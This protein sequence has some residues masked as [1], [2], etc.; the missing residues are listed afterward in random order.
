[1]AIQY[2]PNQPIQLYKQVGG[3][4]IRQWDRTAYHKR[5]G[6]CFFEGPNYCHPVVNT[7]YM[8]FQF[9]ASEI[10][11]DLLL[12]SITT[13]TGS[14]TSTTTDH[15]IDSGADFVAAGIQLNNLVVNINDNTSAYVDNVDSLTNL[16]LSEDIF[17]SFPNDYIIYNINIDGNWKFNYNTGEFFVDNA[18][19]GGVEFPSILNV[20]SWYAVTINVT[21]ITAGFISIKLGNNTIVNISSVGTHTVYGQCTIV[22]D[23]TFV[24]SS[25]FL[26]AFDIDDCTVIEMQTEYTIAI[27]DIDGVFQSA[28]GG[29]F[30]DIDALSIGNIIINRRWS[31]FELDCGKYIVAVYEGDVAP[32][33]G[34]MVRN[35]NFSSPV[36]WATDPPE[37]T[38]AGGAALFADAPDGSGLQNTL[39]C[40]IQEERSYTL[41][42]DINPGSGSVKK[43]EYFILTAQGNIGGVI[44][45]DA[46]TQTGTQSL[47]F[48]ATANSSILSFLV[49]DSGSGPATFRLDNVTLTEDDPTLDQAD[50]DGL[51]ECYCVCDSQD[52][53]ILIKYTADRPTFGGAYSSGYPLMYF[54]VGGR[55][56]NAETDDVEYNPFKSTLDIQIGAYSNLLRKEELIVSHA[57]EWVHNTMAVAIKHPTVYIDDIN[58]QTVSAYK[59]NWGTSIELCEGSAGVAQVNQTSLRNNY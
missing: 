10:G 31:D 8:T 14:N 47:S 49:Y 1:M 13:V 42:W 27:F 53:T 50:A 20:G 59:P 26:G 30:M 55:L 12:T 43:G 5:L 4:N 54:R 51:S 9:K 3:T 17:S 46:S 52:C 19:T 18:G 48:L 45:F 24:A 38:I 58:Y 16:T 25:A 21:D 23:F 44:P 32:C 40:D 35:G 37:I 7:D 29:A 2:L 22:Q 6:E 11:D 15:L 56:R 36:G 33:T 28:I 41:R 57:P 34:E 39:S